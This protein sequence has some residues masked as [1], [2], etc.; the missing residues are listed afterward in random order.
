MRGIFIILLLT[1]LYL[2]YLR[3]YT[4]FSFHFLRLLISLPVSQNSLTA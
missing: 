1:L 3:Y 4:L 2:T